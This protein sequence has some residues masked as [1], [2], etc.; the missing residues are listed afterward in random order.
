VPEQNG[1]PRWRDIERL[2]KHNE[3]Q[4]EA[5][6]WLAGM[7]QRNNEQIVVLRKDVDNMS[8]DVADVPVL[9]ERL[10]TAIDNMK[11]IRTALYS[12]AASLIVVAAAVVFAQ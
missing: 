2:D 12:A 6:K 9:R 1:A 4:D 8:V 7:G 5:F 10:D 3:T 11:S